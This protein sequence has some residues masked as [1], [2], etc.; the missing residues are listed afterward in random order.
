MGVPEMDDPGLR[1]LHDQGADTDP[2][3]SVSRRR[4]L[5]L[6]AGAEAM[7]TAL[8]AGAPAFGRVSEIGE[9]TLVFDNL[10]TGEKLRA[11]YW[12]DGAY[13]P[14]A[15]KEIDWILRDFRTAQTIAIHPR[16][17]DVLHLLQHK[18][19]ARGPFQVVSA[20]RSPATNA[21]LRRYSAGV[22]K[23]SLHMEG[24]AIDLRL[25]GCGLDHLHR[26]ALALHAGGVGYYP[27]SDFIHID[28]GRPRRWHG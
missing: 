28:V 7:G 1:D 11:V 21:M 22:A 18:V 19:G 3:Q 8:L 14:G 26:A 23:H 6:C 25:A 16:L 9:R 13:R 15:M 20:Y 4:F 17:L 2:A 12:G 24:K 27:A 5:R 10:H